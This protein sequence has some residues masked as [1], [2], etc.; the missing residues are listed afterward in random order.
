MLRKALL[1]TAVAA[2]VAVPATANAG[3]L[4]VS[5]GGKTSLGQH[6]NV[7]AKINDTGHVFYRGDV[8]LNG[9]TYTNLFIKCKAKTAAK[10]FTYDFSNRF[11]GTEGAFDVLG[12]DCK[13]NKNITVTVDV[14]FVDRGEPGGGTDGACFYIFLSGTGGNSQ[15]AFKDCGRIQKGNVQIGKV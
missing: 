13:T 7:S 10:F 11:P 4:H 5:G 1:A 12:V 6:Y 9:T 14:T 3:Q 15:L 8:T 2:L